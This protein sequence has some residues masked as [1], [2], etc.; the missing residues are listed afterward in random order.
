MG[1]RGM[2]AAPATERIYG[3]VELTRLIKG[4]LESGYPAVWVRGEI[5]GLKRAESGHIYL[6]LKEGRDAVLSAVI[7]RATL[8]RLSFELRDGLEVEAFGAIQ[9]YEPRGQ[10][11]LKINELRPAGLGA[12]LLALEELKRKLQAEGL[13]DEARKRAPPRFPRR[14]GLVTS[15]TGAAVRDM[16]RVLRARW[17][18]IA[19][20][21]APVR[22][23]GEGAAAEIAG[24]I[25][26]MNRLGTPDLLIVGR[27]GGSIEDLWAFNEEK[28]VRA[29]AG[30][31]IPVITA[32]GHEVDMTLADF[33]ADVRAATP[34]HAAEV[35]VP[36]RAEVAR[37]VD[38]LDRRIVRAVRNAIADRRRY[39]EAL[40]EKYSFRRLR[41]FFGL[42][43]QRVDDARTRLAR[44]L[45]ALLHTG[46]IRID[47]FAGRLRALSPRLV[48]ERGYCLAR[49]AD[50]TLLR[51]ADALAIG[52]RFAVEFARGAADARVEAIRGGEENP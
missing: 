30:S 50:G 12:L 21:L 6:T 41:D 38:A 5:S 51:S 2:G 10:Y 35:A 29:I 18:S 13:F 1:T 31:R 24:A 36:D 52:D 8:P 25:A 33:A 20:V 4:T 7:W 3:V 26:A 48:L 43:Q 27:G 14:I 34:S 39:L 40:L 16:V 32:I 49:D 45:I 28:V 44:A 22:V 15:P 46:R 47:G 19:I 23:Q 11:Q 17:P 37:R 42:T 9:L